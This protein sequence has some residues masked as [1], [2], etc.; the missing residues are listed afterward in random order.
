MFNIIFLDNNL[1]DLQRTKEYLESVQNE[2]KYDV[3]IEYCHEESQMFQILNAKENPYDIF[4]TDIKMRNLSGIDIARKIR[5]EQK[6]AIVIFMTSHTKYVYQSFEYAVFRYI[7]KDHM[8]E[9]LL[10]AL[11]AACQKLSISRETYIIIKNNQGIQKVKSS[12]IMYF[13]ME[14]RKCI[15]YTGRER[16]EAWKNITQLKNELGEEIQLFIDIYRG[17]LVNKKHIKKV[18]KNE[19]KLVL[20]NNM[21]LPISRR[22]KKL[23]EDTMTQYWNKHK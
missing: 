12:D 16:I 17:C 21:E 14:N 15:I 13:E 6:N 10:P 18:L 22:K 23:I 2:I 4:V 19:N 20:D 8:N 3:N 11:Q 1:A 9:E 5:D 7:R